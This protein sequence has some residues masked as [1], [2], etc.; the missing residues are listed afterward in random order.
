MLLALSCSDDEPSTAVE[1]L[2]PVTPNPPAAETPEP[3]ALIQLNLESQVG[4]LLDEIPASIRERVATSLLAKDDE[5]WVARAKRQLALA[6]YRLNFRAAYYEEEKAQLPLPP[7]SVL[8]IAIGEGGA[9]RESVEG[10]DYVLVDYA[11]ETVVINTGHGLKTLDAVSGSVGPRA[12][13]EPSYDAF[14]ASGIA[15][16]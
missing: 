2:N 9:R 11:L 5:F 6:N 15:T 10:H 12:T 7:E 3:G 16:A 8:Q 13:I 1:P 4:V 14:V